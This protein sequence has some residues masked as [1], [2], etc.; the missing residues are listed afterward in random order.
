MISVV[1]ITRNRA[2][3]LGD[4]SLPS[5]LAQDYGEFEVILWDAS[6][7]ADSYHVAESFRER[8]SQRRIFFRFFCNRF[9][10]VV[11]A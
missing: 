5:L 2:L 4:I 1:I 7:T 10:D 9:W 6:D 8:F 11:N 3:Q